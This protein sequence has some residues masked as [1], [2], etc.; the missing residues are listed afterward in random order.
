M[1][2]RIG[3]IAFEVLQEIIKSEKVNPNYAIDTCAGIG[4][5]TQNVIQNFFKNVDIMEQDGKFIKQAKI[6]FKNIMKHI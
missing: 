4:R 1:N 5:V 3:D 6:N 2:Y